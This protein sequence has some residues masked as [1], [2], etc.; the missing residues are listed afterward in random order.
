MK[1]IKTMSDQYNFSRPEIEKMIEQQDITKDPPTEEPFRQY[2]FIKKMRDY[3][4]RMS[5]ELGRP[6]T[7][8][9]KTFGCQMIF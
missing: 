2:Y 8:C 6:L 3:V 9:T 1:G 4:K 5:A 7:A